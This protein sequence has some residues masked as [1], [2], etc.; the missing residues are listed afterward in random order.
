LNGRVFD[1]I[2]PKGVKIPARGSKRFT[3]DSSQ[4]NMRFVS[5]DMYER[6]DEQCLVLSTETNDELESKVRFETQASGGS[7]T[8]KSAN[9]KF[10]TMGN[11]KAT[12]STSLTKTET[13]YTYHLIATADVP[14]PPQTRD[15]S[16][17]GAEL[18]IEVV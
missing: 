1:V 18:Q 11:M 16:T 2:I 5:L 4:R 10:K 8:T 17:L 9:R 14:I 3:L 15:A 7:K 6:I 13:K 12:A